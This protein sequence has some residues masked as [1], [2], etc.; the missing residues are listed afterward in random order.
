MNK[1]GIGLYFGR[2]PL[3]TVTILY[4][5]T[6]KKIVENTCMYTGYEILF[7]T[8]KISLLQREMKCMQ[9]ISEIVWLCIF[10]IFSYESKPTWLC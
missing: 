3:R 2:K 6:I 10:T 1:S 9:F 5:A 7:Q 4:S 8:I